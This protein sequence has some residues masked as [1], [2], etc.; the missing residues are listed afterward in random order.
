[1]STMA[2][3]KHQLTGIHL[4]SE[5]RFQKEK[6]FASI[7]HRVTVRQSRFIYDTP[8]SQGDPFIQI[9]DYR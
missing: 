3:S 4:P 8:R 1:M 2:V 9:S 5:S 6:M 7:C